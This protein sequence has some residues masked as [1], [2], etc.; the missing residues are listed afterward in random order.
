MY[1]V[2]AT[3]AVRLRLV[4]PA[5]PYWRRK[6]RVRISRGD[7]PVGARGACEATAGACEAAAG[8]CE[9]TDG[10][11]SARLSASAAP[12][13]AAAVGDRATMRPVRCKRLQRHRFYNGYRP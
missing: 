3:S 5:G 4:M 12:A 9:A 7:A 1:S 10:A 6:A 11:P 2:S 8:A 13:A